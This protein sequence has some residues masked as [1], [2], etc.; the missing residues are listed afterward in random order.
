ML[1][2]GLPCTVVQTSDGDGGSSHQAVTCVSP[3]RSVERPLLVTV[4][5]DGQRSL[6]APCDHLYA[7]PAVAGVTPAVVGAVAG[8]GGRARVTV[9]GVNFGVR[10]LARLP[11]P[12]HPTHPHAGAFVARVSC[13][14]TTYS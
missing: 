2:G 6:G 3:A 9:T 7:G 13:T 5:V 1:V 4:E 11:P 10:S 8:A 12:P 14:A